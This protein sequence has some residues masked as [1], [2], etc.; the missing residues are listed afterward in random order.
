MKIG[1]SIAG[2]RV[3]EPAGIDTQAYFTRASIT[4]NTE[5]AA[6]QTFADTI[7]SSGLLS[8]VV[9]IWPISPTN[10]AAAKVELLDPSATTDLVEQGSGTLT[11]DA[12]G[13]STDGSK[14]LI[15]SSLGMVTAG[16]SVTDFGM[17]YYSQNAA[18]GVD[19]TLVDFTNFKFTGIDVDTTNIT[20]IV[21][22]ASPPVVPTVAFSD[23][24][25][26]LRRTANNVDIF[27]FTSKTTGTGN[28]TAI[29]GDFPLPI[30]GTYQTPSTYQYSLNGAKVSFYAW[31]LAFSDA[32]QTTWSNAVQALQTA[33]SRNA[34]P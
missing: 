24:L 25:Y 12:S 29:L 11:H 7:V 26:T 9:A 28:G 13:V 15:P 21:G 3:P 32:E 20:G 16:L 5:K 19:A 4:D 34:T 23:G 18:V 2:I 27:R 17:T 31:H 10:L 8:K 1:I 33:L 22:D 14:L 6:I 30:L